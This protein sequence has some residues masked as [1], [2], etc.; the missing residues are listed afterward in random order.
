MAGGGKFD[1]T[2]VPFSEFKKKKLENMCQCDPNIRTPHCGRGDCV[3]PEQKDKKNKRA[4]SD[5]K[6]HI[7]ICLGGTELGMDTDTALHLYKQLRE[8]IKNSI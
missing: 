4:W 2:P 8:A 3:S 1:F 6:D 7:V 5:F